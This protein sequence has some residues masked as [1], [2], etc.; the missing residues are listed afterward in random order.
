VLLAEQ[1]VLRVTLDRI[2]LLVEQQLRLA[3]I[4]RVVGGDL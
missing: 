1:A 2:N 4:E 3:Q